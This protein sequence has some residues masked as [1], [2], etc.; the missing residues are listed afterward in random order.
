[1]L[2]NTQCYY[3]EPS[4][5]RPGP[6]AC[7]YK[8]ILLTRNLD[9]KHVTLHLELVPKLNT[10]SRVPHLEVDFL[11]HRDVLCKDLLGHEKYVANC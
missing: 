2:P 6:K 1:M 9:P 3:P 10:C 11:V 7:V 5:L 8:F 4:S